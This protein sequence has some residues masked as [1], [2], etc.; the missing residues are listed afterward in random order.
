MRLY[1]IFHDPYVIKANWTYDINLFK[2]NAIFSIL[3]FLCKVNA[4]FS[5][6]ETKQFINSRKPHNAMG[7]FL[8]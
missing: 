7:N 2:V 4:A 6:F 5:L 3:S 1:L 8:L